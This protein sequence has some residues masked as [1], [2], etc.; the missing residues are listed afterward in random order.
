MD[1]Y[2]EIEEGSSILV[3]LGTVVPI[4]HKIFS[5]SYG[6]KDFLIHLSDTIIVSFDI[7]AS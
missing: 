1:D 2:A 6:K 3:G 5:T 4:P 7:S